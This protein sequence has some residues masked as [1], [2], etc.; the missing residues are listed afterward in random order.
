[1]TV[2]YDG[3]GYV[4]WQRQSNGRSIQG[5]LEEAV[6]AFCGETVRVFGAGRTDAGVHAFGQ[7]AHVDLV[8]PT[9]AARLRA[10]LNAHLGGQPISVR[11]AEP[12]EDG[13]DARFSAT[14]RV[15]LYRILN[16][17]A[18]PALDRGR[19]W[20]VGTPLDAEA[21]QEGASRLAGRHDFTAFRAVGCQARS[22]VK[23][24]DA[25]EVRRHGEEI[26]VTARARSF[27][28]R[29]VRNMVGTLERVG[30]G[31]WSPGDVSTALQARD[32]AAAGPTAPARGL[33]LLSV[34]YDGR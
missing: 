8:R 32:R 5:A 14:G 22:P 4:G 6:L 25:L 12:V 21:M 28:H 29:Q 23:T 19:V 10:A 2:E 3:E 16:R 27:L 1:M 11:E 24:L 18:P 17:R 33:Y 13:F 15:Y 7:V 26:R 31:S 20:H 34:S 30:A 9:D